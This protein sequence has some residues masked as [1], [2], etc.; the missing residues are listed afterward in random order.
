MRSNDFIHYRDSF[1]V[2][3][4]LVYMGVYVVTEVRRSIITDNVVS[5]IRSSTASL[6]DV[7]SASVIREFNCE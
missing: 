3:M 2:P 5:S 7:D 1:C 4:W 6:E